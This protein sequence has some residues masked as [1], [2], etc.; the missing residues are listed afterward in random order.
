MAGDDRRRPIVHIGLHKTATSWFQRAVWPHVTTHRVLDR[1]RVRA[2]ILAPPVFAFD[3]RAARAELELDAPGPPPLIC[4]EDLSGVLHNGLASGYVAREAAV[5]VR[6]LLPDARIALF[7]RAQPAAILSSY[8][9]YLR[10]G[11]TASLARYLFPEAYRHLGHARP[12]KY[13]KFDASAFDYRPLVEHYDG[14]FG[15]ENVHVFAYEHLAADPEALIGEMAERL[16]FRLGDPPPVARRVNAGYRAGL[17][18]LARFFNLFTERAVPDKRTLAHIPYWYIVRKALLERLNRLPVFG[19]KPDP[20][21]AL[22]PRVV[23]W[24]DQR[25]WAGNRWLARRMGVD[26][27]ALGYALDPPAAPAPVPI[28]RRRLAWMRN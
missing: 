8:Q 19:R 27:K 10:E 2:A 18:P 20:A 12:F 24:L 22:G 11:G 9:Q 7:V 21:A 28:A 4:E 3:A 1:E 13:P 25:F 23:A 26:L 14:L 15:R 6:E 16:A 5:R 17:M